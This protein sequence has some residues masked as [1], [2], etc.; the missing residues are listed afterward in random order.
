M[1]KVLFVTASLLSLVVAADDLWKN[2]GV[3]LGPANIINCSGAG[4]TCTRNGNT[5]NITI[6]SD[7]GYGTVITTCDA[8]SGVTNYRVGFSM[9][10]TPGCVG[11]PICSVACNA[12]CPGGQF[13]T[14]INSSGALICGTPSGGGTVT[15]VTGSNGVTS[16]G[17]TTPDISGV[18][19]GAAVTGV[20]CRASST[21]PL[22][23]DAGIH[24]GD[25]VVIEVLD[26]GIALQLSSN[27]KVSFKSSGGAC[28]AYSAPLDI[29]TLD[30]GFSI[31]GLNRLGIGTAAPGDSLD[32]ANGGLMVR[33]VSAWPTGIDGFYVEWTGTTV[34]LISAR[35]GTAYKPMALFGSTVTIKTSGAGTPNSTFEDTHGLTLDLD[36]YLRGATSA[37]ELQDGGRGVDGQCFASG[38]AGPDRWVDCLT[39][40]PTVTKTYPWSSYCADTVCTGGGEL[41]VVGDNFLM[42]LNGV[43]GTLGALT[44]NVNVSNP[45]AGNLVMRVFNTI[46][47]TVTCDCTA[48]QL[49]GGSG[50]AAPKGVPVGCS[51]HAAAITADRVYHMRIATTSSCTANHGQMGCTVAIDQ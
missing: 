9:P 6:T 28:F 2:Q 26:A 20:V 27:S 16:S 12:A 35:P 44:C 3:T 1:R 49:D 40:A 45:T 4:I 48:L 32:V 47:G 37:I 8:G 43:S 19:A 7:G 13:A 36:L 50:C 22:W 31:L 24:L 10:T 39:S 34:H 51:C 15:D 21:G 38:G 5:A 17:G 25:Q 42:P 23:I 46:D 41:N 29:V 33:G 30:G 11:L 14:G 18:C